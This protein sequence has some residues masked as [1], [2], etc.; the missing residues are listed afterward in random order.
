MSILSEMYNFLRFV[1]IL[2]LKSEFIF[3]NRPFY[4]FEDSLVRKKAPKMTFVRK[5]LALNV[6]EIDY[7]R[8]R[9]TNFFVSNVS[10]LAN[11]CPK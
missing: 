3:G 5:I 4:N 11:V 1:E 2:K 9:A 8:K 10:S 7:R 6:D